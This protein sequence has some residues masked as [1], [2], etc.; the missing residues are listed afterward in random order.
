MPHI[1][2]LD[3]LNDCNESQRIL[4]KLPDWLVSSWNRKAMEARHATS[5][6][7]PFKVFEDFLSKEADLACDPISSIQALKSIESEKPKQLRSQTIQAKTLSTNTTQSNISSCVFCKGTGHVL[8]KCRKFIERTVQDCVK[9]VQAERLCFGCLKT[10]H[11]SKMCDNKGT[12]EICQNRHPT[13][14]HDD[15]FMQNQRPIPPRGGDNAKN[16]TGTKEIAATATTNRDVQGL[17]TQTSSIIPVWVSSIK[18]PDQEVLVYALLET[19]SDT[20]FILD[21]VAQE[22]NTTKENVS[23]R[24]STMSSMSTVIPCQKL[25]SLQVRG[26]NLQKRI[27]LPPLFTR[28]FI[29]ADRSH[30]PTAETALKWSHLKQLADKIPPPLDCEVG[31]LIGYN[32]HHQEGFSLLSLQSMIRWGLWLLLY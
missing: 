5:E 31:L 23:L 24:L 13:C 21:E 18:H 9:F 17:N 6:Y 27:R 11:H 15:K 28:E 2:S 1:K 3:V 32:C 7:P 10:G 14:L 26:Y 12:C 22:L 16:G 19:Q 20:T 8:A 30:I 29:L 25:T 4:L